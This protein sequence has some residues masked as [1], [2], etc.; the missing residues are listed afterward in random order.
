MEKTVKRILSFTLILA[1]SFM[2]MLVPAYAADTADAT[3]TKAAALKQL[4][5]FKGMSATDFDLDR[6]PTR[7]EAMVM[8]I[9]ALGQ[10]KEALSGSWS[11]PF[12]DVAS[13]ADKY[14]GYAYEKGLT[15]GMSS[16]QFGAGNADADMY[17][18]FMLRALGYSDSAGDF[19]WDAPDTLAASVGIL[20]AGVDTAN[21]LRGDTA[22]VSWA[23]LEAGL[24]GGSQTLSQKLMDMKVFTSAE[25][26]A[27]KLFAEKDG[28]VAVS[29]SAELQT[30]VDNKDV[31]VIQI[32]S[33]MDI[34]GELLFDCEAGPAVLIYIKEGVTLT[35]SGELI[36]LGCSFTNDG[37]MAITGTFDRG[38]G[39]LANNGTITVKSGG[40]FES[41]MTDTCN[42]GAVAVESGGKLM[43]ERGTQFYNYGNI[44][45][46][47][48]VSVD[49]GGSLT[50]DTGKI[51]NNGAIDLASYFSGNLADITGTGTI[52][53]TRQ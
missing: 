7:T 21:F 2:A 14:I 30:A 43:I 8:L 3:E 31:A 38:L 24:K 48:Y 25:Y 26:D 32:A 45:N 5:L 13:W 40:V 49:N 17:L 10:E 28:G 19:A 12:T 16:T 42:Y 27:A 47:G 50:N 53:D 22:L 36:A 23:A 52:N 37:S 46:N 1:L 20:P 33:D 9:R 29:T 15:K 39:S 18:T 4:R 34:S 35:V 6:A 44:A 11:H 51:V 41:G